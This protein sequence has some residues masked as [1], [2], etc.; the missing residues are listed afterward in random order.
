MFTWWSSA[1][2]SEIETEMNQQ[3]I[4]HTIDESTTKLL[5]EKGIFIE[6]STSNVIK[7]SIGVMPYTIYVAPT[8]SKT[9]Q[10][11]KR[12]TLQ[13]RPPPVDC[14]NYQTLPV[15]VNENTSMKCTC[16]PKEISLSFQPIREVNA[17]TS[18]ME[19]HVVTLRITPALLEKDG[20][21]VWVFSFETSTAI[22]AVSKGK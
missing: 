16:T 8:W 1:E 19:N 5:E 13:I 9:L 10:C 15:Y 22:S 2:Y 3:K 17:I 4:Q 11:P 6:H 7:L 12:W 18:I 21:S 14:V 20:V